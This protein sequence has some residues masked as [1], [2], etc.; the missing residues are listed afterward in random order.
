M[1]LS[2][3]IKHLQK[4]EQEREIEDVAVY[5]DPR[6]DEFL[7]SFSEKLCTVEVWDNGIKKLMICDTHTAQGI[8]NG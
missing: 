2:A 7:K 6:T 1:K 5:C 4:I 8:L 3:F